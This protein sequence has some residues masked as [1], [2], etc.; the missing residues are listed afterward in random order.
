M[1]DLLVLSATMTRF[2]GSVCHDGNP[3]CWFWFLVLSDPAVPPH[4]SFSPCPQP[5][6]SPEGLCDGG[7]GQSDVRDAEGGVFA[8]LPAPP[9]PAAWGRRPCLLLP[10]LPAW[11]LPLSVCGG[12]SLFCFT[13]F[14]FLYCQLYSFKGQIK[15]SG[16]SL[17][18][19]KTLSV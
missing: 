5:S 7:T 6:W 13:S 19:K 16:T 3:F 1:V 4:L 18:Q 15:I 17:N 11:L 12:V 8:N 14:L 2:G 10:L 9:A